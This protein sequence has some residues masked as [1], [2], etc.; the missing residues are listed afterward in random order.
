MSDTT[1]ELYNIPGFKS[2]SDKVLVV[3]EFFA[4]NENRALMF[5]SF[6]PEEHAAYMERTYKEHCV[7]AEVVAEPANE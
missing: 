5:L 2:N 1:K 7:V 6:H 4:S 3:V